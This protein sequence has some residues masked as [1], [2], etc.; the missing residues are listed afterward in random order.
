MYICL[1]F[2]VISESLHSQKKTMIHWCFDQNSL[3]IFYQLKIQALFGHLHFELKKKIIKMSSLTVNKHDLW[4]CIVAFVASGWSTNPHGEI[5]F[6][7]SYGHLTEWLKAVNDFINVAALAFRHDPEIFSLSCSN[8]MENHVARMGGESEIFRD[9][10][11]TLPTC[12]SKFT[13]MYFYPNFVISQKTKQKITR[14]TCQDVH[15]ILQCR[16]KTYALSCNDFFSQEEDKLQCKHIYRKN[17]LVHNK[18][19]QVTLPRQTNR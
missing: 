8:G 15:K 3:H 14:L 1:W 5:V 18:K 11:Y 17:S 16:Q 12:D 10:W 2:L 13:S 6:W 4:T 7:T 9:R 19:T